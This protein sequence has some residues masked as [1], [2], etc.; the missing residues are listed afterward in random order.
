MIVDVR[1]AHHQCGHIELIAMARSLGGVVAASV[2]IGMVR[3]CEATSAA[4][5]CRVG[6]VWRRR[7]RRVV[8][9]V[10]GNGVQVFRLAIELATRGDNAA[11]GVDHELVVGDARWNCVGEVAG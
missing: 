2:L 1:D 3:W 7:R 6:L 10:D 5:S 9:H 4:G 11:D 8:C